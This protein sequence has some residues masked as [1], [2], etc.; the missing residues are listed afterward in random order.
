MKKKLLI[1]VFLLFGFAFASTFFNGQDSQVK[2]AETTISTEPSKNDGT[3]FYKGEND[4]WEAEFFITKNM[5]N[6]LRV[7]PKSTNNELPKQLTFTLSTAFSQDKKQ[8]QLGKFTVS[9]DDFPSELSLHFKENKILKP[10]EENL[11]L[12]ITGEGHYQFFNM[13]VVD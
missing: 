7:E 13:Y 4:F 6:Q 10:L 11:V 5:V 1:A 2:K 12:K 8:H 3:V 9:F